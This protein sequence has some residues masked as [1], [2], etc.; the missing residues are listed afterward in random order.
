M[1]DNLLE[2]IAIALEKIAQPNQSKTLGF[3]SA[4]KANTYVFCNRK[5]GGVW[6][7]LDDQSQPVIID[8]QA[9]SGHIRKIEFKQVERRKEETTKMHVYVEAD[10]NYVLESG[11]KAH[12]TKGFLSA[13]AS[14]SAGELQQPITLVPQASTENAEV[15]FCNVYVGDRQ[16]FAPYDDETDWRAIAGTAR[17]K[18]AA[19]NPGFTTPGDKAHATQTSGI[20]ALY[21][22]A[23]DT[24]FTL[25]ALVVMIE[26]EMKCALDQV[27]P[28]QLKTVMSWLDS[29]DPQKWNTYAAQS[30]QQSA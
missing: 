23:E 17:D 19:V 12:F 29:E 25:Q 1:D 21:K 4:P 2:R 10:Q 26:Q 30:Q 3:G 18:I 16:I 14:L 28:G 27:N 15:L 7:R 13:I 5:H 20:K 6:Y 24:G 9:L 8:H 11:S 22:K